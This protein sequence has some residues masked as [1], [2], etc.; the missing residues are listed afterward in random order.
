MK[1]DQPATGHCAVLAT[2]STQVQAIVGGIP[3]VYHVSQIYE[4]EWNLK[5]LHYETV[6]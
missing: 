1:L 2:L 4:N 5:L 3:G 6:W